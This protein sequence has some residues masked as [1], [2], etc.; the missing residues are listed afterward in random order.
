MFPLVSLRPV[1]CS[2]QLISL[3]HTPWSVSSETFASP[4]TRTYTMSRFTIPQWTSTHLATAAKSQ[5]YDGAIAY[6]LEM[7]AYRRSLASLWRAAYFLF[8]VCF[9]SWRQLNTEMISCLLG[10]YRLGHD[11][12]DPFL[13]K[14]PI[15]GVTLPFAKRLTPKNKPWARR[16]IWLEIPETLSKFSLLL[17]YSRRSPS[18][19]EALHAIGA[20]H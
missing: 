5:A 20:T 3:S 14:Q 2:C 13:S 4:W 10:Q 12:N 16:M 1:N 15:P 19:F 17:R 7:R 11:F 9:L 8:I 6:P 18:F